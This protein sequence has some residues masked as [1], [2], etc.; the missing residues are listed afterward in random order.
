M[1][2]VILFLLLLGVAHGVTAQPKARR[3]KARHQPI[4]R[5][6]VG[7]QGIA[8]KGG[9]TALRKSLAMDWTYYFSPA[10]KMKLGLGGAWAK[11]TENT[12]RNLFT[13][14]VLGYTL[15]SNQRNLFLSMLGGTILTYERYQ[16]QSKLHYTLA[17]SAKRGI[18][19]PKQRGK[20]T[21]SC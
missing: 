4:L 9:I 2:R 8:L 11:Q 6:T 13:Q 15:L 14:P 3:I 7:M 12:Y 20:K 5:H 21:F 1:P 19:K 10:W 18:F 17:Q 16:N